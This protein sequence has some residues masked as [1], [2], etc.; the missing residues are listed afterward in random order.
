MFISFLLNLQPLNIQLVYALKLALLN[1]R[2]K[3]GL[4]KGTVLKVLIHFLTYLI[5]IC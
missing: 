1:L 2:S 4:L 3:L 5:Y